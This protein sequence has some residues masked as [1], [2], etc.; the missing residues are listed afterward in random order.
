MGAE[1]R[2]RLGSF[3]NLI[4]IDRGRKR[5]ESLREA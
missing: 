3:K 1:S 2:A 4:E 5:R